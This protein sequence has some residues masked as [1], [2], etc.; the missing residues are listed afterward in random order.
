MLLKRQFISP[1]FPPPRILGRSFPRLS[2]SCISCIRW[3][4]NVCVSLRKGNGSLGY[5]LMF[6]SQFILNHKQHH[7]R[8][9]WACFLL[10]SPNLVTAHLQ[11]SAVLSLSDDTM[12]RT[13]AGW[14]LPECFRSTCRAGTAWPCQ[15]ERRERALCRARQD[16]GICHWLLRGAPL[17]CQF[18]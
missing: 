8:T 6:V 2:F 1:C 11:V 15:A 16:R 17:L 13:F 14:V 12:L 5:F 3:I 7:S 10:Q 4:Y 9:E 18:D